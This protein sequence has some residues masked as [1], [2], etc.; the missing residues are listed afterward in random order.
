MATVV[1]PTPVWTDS[2]AQL[3]AQLT[4]E[5]ELLI[6]CDS[7]ADPVFERQ[8]PAGVRRLV[9]GDPTGC[10]GK[11][12]AVATG[13]EAASYDRIILTDNDLERG[14]YWL[15]TM[16]RL[17]EQHGAVTAIPVFVSDRYPFRLLEPFFA[18][19]C[20]FGIAISNVPWGGGVSFDR[21]EMDLEGYVRDLR[22]T[23]ADDVLLGEYLDSVSTAWELVHEV[24]VDGGPR[25]TLERVTRFVQSVHRFDR[26]KTVG[27]IGIALV[28]IG[29]MMVVPLVAIGLTIGMGLWYRQLGVARRSWLLTVPA[30]LVT[31]FV[32]AGGIARRR[33]QWGGR[34]YD[35]P[36]RF[37]V[38]VDSSE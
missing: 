15:A 37:V 3:A 23:V 21:Q 10:S 35:W 29:L 2:C 25:A 9:A 8:L 5:D 32:L 13:L 30:V 19:W 1:L 17:G 24:P 22:R 6:V 11:A 18:C 27:P 38:A 31:P 28:L 36:S 7:Q 33:F 34:Q 12:N 4:D 20:S 16:K 26:L 14:P